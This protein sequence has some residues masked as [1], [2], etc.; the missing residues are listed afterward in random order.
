MKK[1]IIVLIVLL[2]STKWCSAQEFDVNEARPAITKYKIVSV[3]FN[4]VDKV[5]VA[6]LWLLDAG[7]NHLAGTAVAITGVQFDTLLNN[8][9]IDKTALTNAI[10]TKMGK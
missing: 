10:K 5:A 1:W 4:F 8:I 9:S 3:E 2:V 7:G 6:N